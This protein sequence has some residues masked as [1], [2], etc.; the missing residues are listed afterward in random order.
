MKKAKNEDND[1]Y[2]ASKFDVI[3]IG[4][5]M[6]FSF[7]YVIW[8]AHNRIQQASGAK[9]AFIY[10]KNL[11]LEKIVLE[12]DKTFAIKDGRMQIEIKQGRIRVV[13]SDC[14][15]HICVNMGWIQ[16]SGQ[17]IA[18]VPNQVLIE[19]KSSGSPFLDAVAN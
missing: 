10:Q 11:L 1:F 4:I 3:L 19:V 14:P 17:T 13:K 6:F 5:I 2:K 18:C 15:Q 9:V 12:K 16:Y 7:G 8:V